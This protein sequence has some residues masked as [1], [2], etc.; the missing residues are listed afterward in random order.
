MSLGEA[1]KLNRT[2]K[3]VSKNDLHEKCNYFN[4]QSKCGTP[5]DVHMQ[6]TLKLAS[7]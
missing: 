2:R 1:M 6:F 7:G 4:H 3:E 5:T